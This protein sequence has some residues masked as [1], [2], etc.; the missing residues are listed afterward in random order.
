MF[1]HIHIYIWQKFIFFLKKG[2][3]IEGKE[4]YMKGLGERENKRE[5]I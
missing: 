3:K 1:K 5:M 2:Q 4:E